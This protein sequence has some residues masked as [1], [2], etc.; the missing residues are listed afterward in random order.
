MQSKFETLFNEK[1]RELEEEV[2]EKI[3]QSNKEKK[4]VE[5]KF[6]LMRQSVEKQGESDQ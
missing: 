1:I 2:K 6:E 4:E 5:I 3:S